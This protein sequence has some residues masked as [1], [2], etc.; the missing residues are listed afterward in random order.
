MFNAY[1]NNCVLLMF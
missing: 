1:C